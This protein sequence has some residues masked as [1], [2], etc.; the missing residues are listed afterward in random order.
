MCP[1]S[2]SSGKKALDPLPWTDYFAQEFYLENI[3]SDEIIIHHVYVTLPAPKGSLFVLHHGAG[4]SGLSFALLAAELRKALPNSGVLSVEARG[5]GETIVKS[6]DG[7]IKS[8][9]HDLSL[10]VLS[11]DLA[12]AV[13]I[14]KAKLEWPRIPDL[15]LVG[16][17]LGGP[18]VTDVAMKGTLGSSVLGYAVLDVVEGINKNHPYH[19][20]Q[21]HVG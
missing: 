11:V 18:V 6:P 13:N 5:H 9:P 8:E 4:S 19:G 2:S 14:L 12:D 20:F 1:A 17:S 15:I 21:P 10:D 3:R 7:Q 16:H